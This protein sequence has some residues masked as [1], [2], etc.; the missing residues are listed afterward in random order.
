[1]VAIKICIK[2]TAGTKETVASKR[3]EETERNNKSWKVKESKRMCELTY[4]YK[5][6]KEN[7]IVLSLR[8][9]SCKKTSSL[10]RQ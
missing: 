8:K 3:K 9:Q 10:S 6:K 1:V 2:S 7:E 4:K 5:N